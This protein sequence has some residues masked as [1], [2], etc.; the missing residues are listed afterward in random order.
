[1]IT[2]KAGIPNTTQH[3]L[4]IS[5]IRSFVVIIDGGLDTVRSALFANV[6]YCH[7]P[8]VRLMDAFLSYIGWLV[9]LLVGQSVSRSASRSVVS[10][11]FMLN[12]SSRVDKMNRPTQGLQ[13][14]RQ[15]RAYY[16]ITTGANSQKVSNRPFHETSNSR[17]MYNPPLRTDFIPP[18][19]SKFP[20]SPP[21]RGMGGRFESCGV[22]EG[23]H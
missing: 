14:T 16:R 6:A 23:G 22:K 7:L 20:P 12:E 3:N 21:V 8:R 2:I 5:N 1:M 11:W 15:I 18:R 4:G 9:G 10:R 17:W 13:N 19:A